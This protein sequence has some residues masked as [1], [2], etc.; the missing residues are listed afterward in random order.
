MSEYDNNLTGLLFPE[1]EEKLKQNPK[2]PFMTGNVEIDEEKLR[3][4]SWKKSDEDG[5]FFSLAV[6]ESE[7]FA[8]RG[9]GEL[10][11]NDSDSENAPA[12]KGAVTIDDIEYEVAA[13]PKPWKKYDGEKNFLSIRLTDP[14]APEIVVDESEIDPDGSLDF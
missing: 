14:D 9:N 12:F 13:W 1:D 4:A 8:K 5:P 6:S 2:R 3:I 11:K 10:R 7:G